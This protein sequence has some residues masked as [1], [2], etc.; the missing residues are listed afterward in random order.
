[1]IQIA[2]L[3]AGWPAR[4]GIIVSAVVA[5]IGLR[6]WDVSHQQAKGAVKAVAKI[7][8]AT[9]NATKLGKRAADNSSSGRVRGERDP[10]TRND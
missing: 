1:M 10:S 6:A 5:L 2:A 7:E 3:L 8:K 4:I 9:D